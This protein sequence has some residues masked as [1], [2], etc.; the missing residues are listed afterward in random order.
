DHVGRRA[1]HE[2][3]IVAAVL[4]FERKRLLEVADADG[5]DAG[6]FVH[7]QVDIAERNA[8]AGEVELG[9][10]VDLFAD[11]AL[12]SQA[13]P[14][15]ADGVVDGADDLLIALALADQ[16]RLGL[17]AADHF[18]DRLGGLLVRRPG[19]RERVPL[20]SFASGECESPGVVRT[21][22]WSSPLAAI[23]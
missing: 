11:V 9:D 21:G 1:F 6:Q 16:R 15:K 18:N 19:V 4:S 10:P 20:W 23:Q 5:A 3:E 22:G 7:F 2:G 14:A 8:A 12:G 13:R 17:N